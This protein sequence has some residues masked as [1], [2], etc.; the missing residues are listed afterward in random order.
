MTQYGKY[1]FC[2]ERERGMWERLLCE[3]DVRMG[4]VRGSSSIFMKTLIKVER[5][6]STS[7]VAI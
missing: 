7:L 1:C 2:E 6:P 5:A 3:M 4:A